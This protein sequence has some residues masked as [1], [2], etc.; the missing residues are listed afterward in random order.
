MTLDLTNDEKAALIE[1]LCDTIERDRFPLLPRVKRLRG[2]LAKLGVGSSGSCAPSRRLATATSPIARP[3]SASGPTFAQTEGRR[4]SCVTA[5]RN[6][7]GNYETQS[8]PPLPH[9]I[10]DVGSERFG[11]ALQHGDCRVALTPFDPTQIGLVDFGAVGQ[12]LL[13]EALLASEPLKVEPDTLP[14]VHAG[15]SRASSLP[16]H[17]L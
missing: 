12:L 4:S 16:L 3:R 11:D 9:Q 17:R 13:R 14:H 15:R 6:S 8:L 5:K 10:L 1:V 2:I 7:G